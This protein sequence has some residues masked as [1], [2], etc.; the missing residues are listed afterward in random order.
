MSK[1]AKILLSFFSLIIIISFFF[2]LV[3]PVLAATCICN[4]ADPTGTETGSEVTVKC[5]DDACTQD[6]CGESNLM[7]RCHLAP[8][9]STPMTGPNSDKAPAALKNLRP[10]IE[11][12]IGGFSKDSFDFFSSLSTVA[13]PGGGGDCIEVDWLSKYIGAIYK[14]GVGLAAVLATIMIMVGGFL[15][16]TSAGSPDRVGKAKEFITSALTGL[17]LALFSFIILYTVNPRLVD[18]DPLYVKTF[19]FVE[20]EFG[21]PSW[22]TENGGSSG[23]ARACS[24]G[25]CIIEGIDFTRYAT[26]TTHI[27]SLRSLLSRM[28]DISTAQDAQDYIDRHYPNS[29]VTGEMVMSAA[30]R[31]DV[32]PEVLLAE[33]ALDSRMGT[34]GR[35][36]DSHNPGNVA[37]ADTPADTRSGCKSPGQL[38]TIRG[39]LSCCYPSWQDGV[40]ATAAWM[41]RNKV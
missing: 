22:T 37:N 34:Q 10:E 41:Q 35:G 4:Y 40:D 31:Y 1:S 8:Q 13:C 29:P 25:D 19:D 7:F 39:T 11:V 24:G 21:A 12:E 2:F 14:Y 28:G 26:A 3:T 9:S 16:L 23:G 30:A 32:S 5:P 36:R 6:P 18:L 38:C 20:V 17:F 27:G 15:W 33:M